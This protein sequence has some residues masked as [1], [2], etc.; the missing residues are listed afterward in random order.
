[1]SYLT[2]EEYTEIVDLF[3][4]IVESLGLDWQTVLISAFAALLG[5]IVHNVIKSS[6]NEDICF[7]ISLPSIENGKLR[8]GGTLTNW[9]LALIV[10]AFL[11]DPVIAFFAG[12]SGASVLR[13]ILSAIEAKQRGKNLIV[14]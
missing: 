13:D 3:F 4:E 5:L 12:L 2:E 8:L 7:S 11:V 10:G 6:T 1:V 9:L 14:P